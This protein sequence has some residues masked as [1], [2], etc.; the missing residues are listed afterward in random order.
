M[1]AKRSIYGS[2][3][4]VSTG[5]LRTVDLLRAFLW[6]TDH[7]RLSKDERKAVRKIQARV[8]KCLTGRYGEDDEYFVSEESQWDLDELT[9]I[10]ENHSLPY[11]HFGAHDG[12][13]ADFGWW[14][15][16]D[17]PHDSSFDGL[18]VNDLS[19]V[20]TGYSG[21]VLHV[22]DHGNLTLYTFS[23]GRG[24]EVWGVV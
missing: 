23:R 18:Q 19:K 14:L 15:S 9:N 8:N 16:S 3:G 11:F 7:L 13:G 21:E 22:S 4:R 24:R 2:I 10:L 12:D 5:T 1:K 20:P 6:E 17:F